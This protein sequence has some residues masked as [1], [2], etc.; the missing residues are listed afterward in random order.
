[1]TLKS[2]SNA[3]F[4]KSVVALVSGTALAQGINLV[5]TPWVTRIYG[6]EAYGGLGI[7]LG[8]VSFLVPLA[9][10]CYPMA[11]VLPRVEREV[12]VIAELAIASCLVLLALCFLGLAANSFIGLFELPFAYSLFLLPV[13]V[14]AS[15]CMAILNQYAIRHRKFGMLSSLLPLAALATGSLKV[16]FGYFSPTSEA[17]ISATIIVLLIQCAMVAKL[18]GF[19]I[20]GLGSARI[21]IK[22]L[23]VAKR[24]IRFPLYRMPHMTVASLSQLAPIVMLGFFYGVKEAGYF[25][26]AKSIL[27]VPV[28]LVGKAV[29]DVSYPTISKRRSLGLGNFALITKLTLSLALLSALPMLVFIL[30]GER[31]FALI[32]GEEWRSSGTYA[33]WMSLWFA[34]NLFNRPSAASISVYGLDG[35]LLK[36]GLL[37]IGVCLAGFMTGYLILGNDVASV[38]LFS[39]FGLVPQL[40]IISKVLVTVRKLDGVGEG[41]E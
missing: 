24:Y 35:F 7:Y 21:G 31:L 30:Y 37:N 3:G 20:S 8:L 40:I 15:L 10:L 9:G 13:G 16:M 12:R 5:F 28:T 18:V 17:L 38:A 29:H 41:V 23:L 32:F 33:V 19:R 6:P 27:T 1:M 25:T 22:H 34:F 36:N 11:I 2:D 39:I 4:L 14:A 26:L